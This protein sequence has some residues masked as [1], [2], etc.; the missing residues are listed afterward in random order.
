MLQFW[1]F[2]SQHTLVLTQ[3]CRLR[4]YPCDL[5]K[6][7]P[8]DP[9]SL[10]HV[11]SD[12]LSAALLDRSFFDLFPRVKTY[13]IVGGDPVESPVLDLLVTYLVAHRVRVVLWTTGVGLSGLESLTHVHQVVLM[14]PAIDRT[15]YREYTG[16]DGFESVMDG[17]QTCRHLKKKVLV[18]TTVQAENLPFLP[19]IREWCWHHQV[20]WLMT[21][22][23]SDMVSRD[24]LSHIYH[25]HHVAG[26]SVI[27]QRKPKPGVCVHVPYDALQSPWGWVWLVLGKYRRYLPWVR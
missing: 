10:S 26:V 11:S 23:A 6:P 16:W 13:H 19:D 21:F 18:A 12:R 2:A 14:V 27:R 4:C 17:L 7:Q 22:Y 8:P 20:P 15:Q 5:W 3:V 24:V 9:P 1:D 25:Y